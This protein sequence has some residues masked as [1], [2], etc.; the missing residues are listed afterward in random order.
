[1][2]FMLLA[3][4]LST[5]RFTPLPLPLLLLGCTPLIQAQDSTTVPVWLPSYK[6]EAWSQLRGSIVSSNSAETVYTIFC[7]PPTKAPDDSAACAI[8]GSDR[9]PFTFTEAVSSVHYEF[10]SKSS[11]TLSLGCDL[12]DMAA[13][14]SGTT[15]LGP[16]FKVGPL[17]GPW[18]T[19]LTPVTLTGTEMQWG[20][21]TLAEPPLTSIVSNSHILTYYPSGT[22][23]ITAVT[24]TATPSSN[25]TESSRSLEGGG[26]VTETITGS[27]LGS[28]SGSVTES[29]SSS[30]TVTVTEDAGVLGTA[31]GDATA[32]T[33]TPTS[34]AVKMLETGRGQSRVSLLMMILVAAPFLR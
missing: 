27:G 5:M 29:S 16:D 22:A 34:G 4:S 10:T 23:S 14:C 32:S 6:P 28:G 33:F 11:Y 24:V 21:L 19:T 3:I 9:F 18:E 7:A 2:L 12:A 31:S 26:T 1:M 13:T 15:S 25:P 20:V 17:N 8:G 30:V